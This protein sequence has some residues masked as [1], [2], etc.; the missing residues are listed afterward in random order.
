MATSASVAHRLLALKPILEPCVPEGVRLVAVE[1]SFLGYRSLVGEIFPP[2]QSAAQRRGRGTYSLVDA[3]GK[4]ISES[5]VSVGLFVDPDLGT[6]SEIVRRFDYV[7]GASGRKLCSFY[8]V[9]RLPEQAQTGLET[10]LVAIVPA[11]P[12]SK[13]PLAVDLVRHRH[14]KHGSA[15]TPEVSGY[16]LQLRFELGC[17]TEAD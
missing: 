4:P 8:Y 5:D 13:G 7:V 6:Y 12:F 1:E 11:A 2:H 14:P 9:L 17:L 16:L 3:V 10:Q 15:L